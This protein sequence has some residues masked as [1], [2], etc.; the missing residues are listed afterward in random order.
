MAGRFSNLLLRNTRLGK[1]VHQI[2]L[3]LVS[4]QHKL[5]RERILRIFSGDLAGAYDG[6]VDQRK[7]VFVLNPKRR[8][9]RRLRF[10][11]LV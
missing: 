4:G 11:S 1:L 7:V 10:D 2:D 6:V 8:R 9:Q 5:C 3:A